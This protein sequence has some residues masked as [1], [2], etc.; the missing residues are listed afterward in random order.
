MFIFGKIIAILSLPLAFFMLVTGL[1]P[2]TEKQQEAREA[3]S[4]AF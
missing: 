4:K 3:A 2:V 1:S